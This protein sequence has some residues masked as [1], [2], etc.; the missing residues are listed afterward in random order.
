MIGRMVKR[1]IDSIT[2]ETMTVGQSH[3]ALAGIDHGQNRGEPSDVERFG[4]GAAIMLLVTTLA[5]LA[6]YA[7]VSEGV[8]LHVA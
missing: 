1:S 6:L 4:V 3:A 5:F 2:H 7:S 8:W